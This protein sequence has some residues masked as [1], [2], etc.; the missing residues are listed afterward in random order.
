MIDKE[1]DL[2]ELEITRIMLV[3]GKE[4]I[5]KWKQTHKPLVEVTLDVTD[6]AFVKVICEDILKQAKKLD[7]AVAVVDRTFELITD[8]N[9]HESLLRLEEQ[10]EITWEAGGML[11]AKQKLLNLFLKK[12]C[13]HE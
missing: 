6:N 13:D 11:V 10:R 8:D 3:K 4:E 7:R 12:L 2:R 1:N 9:L 5:D